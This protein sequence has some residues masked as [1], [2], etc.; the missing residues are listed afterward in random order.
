MLKTIRNTYHE[1]PVKFWVLVLASFVDRVG[2]TLIFP[3]FALY[4]TQKFDVGMTQAGVLLGLFSFSGFVGNILGGALTDRFGRRVIVL[5][6]LVISALSSV[7][8]GLVNDLDVFYLLAVIVGLLSDIAGPAWQAM[9]ADI[10]PEEKRSEG[11][12]VQRVAGNLAW[13]VGPTLGG[14]MAAQSYL[15]LFVLD[16]V[17]SLITAAIVYRM[18]PETMPAPVQE[19][20]RGSITRTLI[21]YREVLSD[22]AYM[23]YIFIS[24]LMLVVYIQMYN[25][26]SVYLR[27][28]HGVSPQGYGFLLT[29]SAVT[30]ILFQFWVTRRVKRYPAMLMMA[31]GASFYALGFSMYGFVSA[32]ALFVSAVVLI[33]IGE[34]I[35]MPVGQALAA[36]FAPMD[37]RGRYLAVFSLAWAVPATF[38]PGIAGVILDNY[39]PN[40]VWYAGG[41]LCALAVLGFLWLHQTT[42]SRLAEGQPPEPIAA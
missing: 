21:G 41:I 40:W 29:M 35:V 38:G 10:L 1:F 25:T 23:A 20:D 7:S 22:R 19:G 18:I 34:M 31:L 9:V 5:F 12:S 30:V 15:L 3:F 13:I 24:M 28:V 27:D 26:L 39:N 37:M 2:G 16:A 14:L 11:F 8:M 32:Y 42:R 6:G 17:T 36:N 33:T 4:I